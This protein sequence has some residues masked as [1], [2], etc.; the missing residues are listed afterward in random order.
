LTVAGFAIMAVS[1]V[2]FVLI[3]MDTPIAVVVIAYAVRMLGISMIMM[4]LTTVGLNSLPS[5]LVNHGSAMINTVHYI[6]GSIGTA[7]VVTIYTKVSNQAVP[8]GQMSE[9]AVAQV[10]GLSYAFIAILISVSIGIVISLFLRDAN[11]AAER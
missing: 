9:T 7:L 5:Q 4:P 10:H 8:S 1:T 2:P 11:K 3:R 6:G